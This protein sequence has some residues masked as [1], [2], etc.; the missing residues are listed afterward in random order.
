MPDVDE[1]SAQAAEL[2]TPEQQDAQDP[3]GE[4]EEGGAQ[5]AEQSDDA[6]AAEAELVEIERD[7]KRYAIPKSLEAELLMQSDYTKKAQTVAEERKALE[8]HR[9]LFQQAV[10]IQKANQQAFAAAAAT[11]HELQRYQGV[12]WNALTQADPAQAQQAFMRYQQLRDAYAGQVQTLSRAEQEFASV[13]DKQ[14]RETLQRGAEQLARELPG[15]TKPE[16]TQRLTEQGRSLG[17]SDEELAGLSQPWIVKAL[18]KAS[19]YDAISAKATAKP[20]AQPA[21]VAQVIKAK[22]APKSL[23]AMSMDDWMKARQA[24]VTK[25][26]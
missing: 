4:A 14:R 8:Q 9:Q 5:P 15:F 2:E 3:A 13:Q 16:T 11:A 1:Q 12:D 17:A 25:R 23:E 18:W 7:G 21:A 6:D 24:Q 10:E 22:S 20:Q 26:R 19:Q